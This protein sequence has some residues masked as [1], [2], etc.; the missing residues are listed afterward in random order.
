M[1]SVELT[2]SGNAAAFDTL[3]ELEEV[4]CYVEG[5]GRVGGEK[6][7]GNGAKVL[8]DASGQLL[9]LCAGL[10]KRLKTIAGML[11]IG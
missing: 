6:L 4:R 2:E 5:Q 11:M 7:T 10:E 9:Q 8:K 1:A 3:D